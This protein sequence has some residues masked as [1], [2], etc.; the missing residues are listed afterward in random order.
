MF[1]KILSYVAGT[2][3]VLAIVGFGVWGVLQGNFVSVQAANPAQVPVAQTTAATNVTQTSAVLN[4][5][6]NNNNGENGHVWFEYGVNPDA[7]NGANTNKL[8]VHGVN[9]SG[10]VNESF[11]LTNLDQ[12]RTYYY[13][14]IAENGDGRDAGDIKSFTTLSDGTTCSANPMRDLKVDID[15]RSEGWTTASATYKNNSTDCTYKVGI[16]SY[17]TFGSGQILNQELFDSKTHQLAPGQS[18]TLHITLPSCTAQIDVF[19]GDVLTPPTYQGDKLFYGPWVN[20]NLGYCGNTVIQPATLKLVKTVVNNN[21]GTK[22]VADFKLFMDG[23]QVTS[24]ETKT[25]TFAHAND[26]KTIVV[27]EQNLSGYTASSW[28]TDCSA[29]YLPGDAN[30]D[31]TVNQA[32]KDILTATYNKNQGDAG[33]DSRADF[34]GDNKVDFNDMV[35]LGQNYNTSS[36]G[37]GKIVLR[38]GENKT[39]TIT[40]DDIPPAAVPPAT[41]KLVKTV[42]NNNGGTKTVADFKLF[43]DSTQV[44]SGEVKTFTFANANDTKTVIA[45]EINLPGYSAGSWSGSCVAYFPSGDA[46]KDGNV[47]Q[48]DKDILTATYNKNKG[49]AGYDARADFNGDD[50]VDFNDM[51]ILGQNYNTQTSSTAALADLGDANLDGVVNQTDKDILT[52]TYNKNQGDAGYDTRADFNNDN[53]VDFADLVILGQNYNTSVPAASFSGN[54]KV[55]LRP[56][57]NLTCTITND[58]NPPTGPTTGTLKL[59]KVVKNDNGG[60]KTSADFPLF[61]NS[62][63]VTSGQV[64]TLAPGNY[65][66]SEQNQTGYTAGSWTGHCSADGKVTLN[67]GDEK[68]CTIVNDDVPPTV[69]KGCLAIKKEAY[70]SGDARINPTPVFTFKFDGQN[71]TTNANG[72]LTISDIP[73]GSHTIEEVVPAGWAL[74]SVTPALTNNTVNI[75]AGSGCT[76]LT[77]K[78]KQVAL[79]AVCVANKNPAFITENITYTVTPTGGNGT[80]TYAWSGTDGLTGNASTA[81]KSYSTTGTKNAQVVVTSG[82]QSVTADCQTVIQTA[83]GGGDGF[84]LTCTSVAPLGNYANLP[85]TFKSFPTGGTGTYTYSWTGAVTGTTQNVDTS[86]GAPGTYNATVT[87][88][89]GPDTRTAQCAVSI[90][91]PSSGGGGGGGGGGGSNVTVSVTQNPGQVAGVFLSQVPYTGIGSN[92]KIALFMLALFSWSAWI[93]YLII[94]RK[95]KKNGMSVADVIVGPAGVGPTLAFAGGPAPVQN[96]TIPVMQNIPRADINA[97]PHEPKQAEPKNFVK[98]PFIE[99]MAPKQQPEFYVQTAV[100]EAPVAPKVPTDNSYEKIFS[101]VN[102]SA[103]P[104]FQQQAAPKV[105]AKFEPAMSPKSN[106]NLMPQIQKPQ[107]EITLPSSTEDVLESL[108]MKARELNTIVSADGLEIIA[109]AS[110]NNKHNAGVILHHLVELYKGSEHEVDGD[111]MVLNGEKINKILFSTYLTMTPVFIQWLAMGDDRKTMSFVRMLQM[112]GQTMKDFVMNVVIEL[113]K[114]YRFRVE[115]MGDADATILDATMQWSN[116]E[117]ESV[118]HTLVTAV[119]QTYSSTYSSVK[120]ALVKVLDMSKSKLYQ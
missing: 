13:R 65:T 105:A 50:K 112:Q 16:A 37:N 21:G 92:L 71:Y 109:K 70:T 32:D 34:N 104:A 98:S 42:V 25:F 101:R 103:Q 91:P 8:N 94:K 56:G 75:G 33:Y 108:E 31:G 88:T 66:A 102:E 78:N 96:R 29:Y 28:G 39:C 95:A 44:N 38:P 26:S 51:V 119:D 48:L 46:N 111:W 120:I 15:Y 97:I 60:T 52:A 100:K 80:Y 57:D 114:A 10:L 18:I 87:V 41:L 30:K 107:A 7:T 63:Q 118:I 35:L 93:S 40:N 54:G 90:N 68:T 17:K 62:Q 24:G 2:A 12:N 76:T 20:I 79:A 84:A 116:E 19:A 53:K 81:T 64:V 47:N 6:Y 3:L 1:K 89:S 59:V 83:T 73:V 58:D 9:G 43:M 72:E 49:D 55:V 11:T 106:P 115:N 77:F 86:F 22:Q 27:S 4:G 23:T 61:I 5:T 85:V 110:Q 99:H 82:G 117:L 74:Q 113:D 14:F 67:A 36:T 45:S 69:L